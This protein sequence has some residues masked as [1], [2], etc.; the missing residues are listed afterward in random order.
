MDSLKKTTEQ[1]INELHEGLNKLLHTGIDMALEIGQLLTEKKAEL[2]HGEF[3]QWIRD[4]LTFTDRTARNYMT[5]WENKDKALQ[6]SNLSEAYKML[7][8]PK[9]ENVSDF[10]IL[11]QLMDHEIYLIKVCC[12]YMENDFKKGMPYYI[13]DPENDYNEY[14]NKHLDESRK[15]FKDLDNE[16]KTLDQRINKC[17]QIITTGELIMRKCGEITIWYERLM[18]MWM[19]LDPPVKSKL[20]KETVKRCKLFAGT[21]EEMMESVI[22]N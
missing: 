18:G 15:E 14:L 21:S 10:D 20:N 19:V 7:S 8:E 13:P 17:Q 5:L 22:K 4:N 3:G 11:I 2:K 6:A 16:D 9:T 12:R 1:R